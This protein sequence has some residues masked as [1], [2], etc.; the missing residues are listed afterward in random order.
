MILDNRESIYLE[1]DLLDMDHAAFVIYCA[2]HCFQDVHLFASTMWSLVR[3]VCKI[4]RAFEVGILLS[5]GE[6][7]D[8]ST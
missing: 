3:R 5:C 7:E 2:S 1:M 4:L 6:E 8:M